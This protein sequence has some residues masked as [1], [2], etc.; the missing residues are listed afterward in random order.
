[1]GSG[2]TWFRTEL[3]DDLRSFSDQPAFLFEQVGKIERDVVR[4]V[5]VLGE[6]EDFEHQRHRPQGLA[7]GKDA[8]GVVLRALVAKHEYFVVPR[9]N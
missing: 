8:A 4:F 1:M 9:L 5:P 2:P 6:E 7:A 3:L